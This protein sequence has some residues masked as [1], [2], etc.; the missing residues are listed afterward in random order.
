METHAGTRVL[1]LLPH[2]DVEQLAFL[3]QEVPHHAD[4][5]RPARGQ[6]SAAAGC[7]ERR[8]PAGWGEKAKA[9]STV[10][11][12]K[13]SKKKTHQKKKPTTPIK[14]SISIPAE[15][16]FFFFF[17]SFRYTEEKKLEKNPGTQTRACGD[18]AADEL[19]YANVL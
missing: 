8:D 19:F 14:I 6:N 1:S 7:T 4:A 13:T 3:Q 15:L 9:A 10:G 17:F 16:D 11:G 2:Q 5:V 18:S 12:K